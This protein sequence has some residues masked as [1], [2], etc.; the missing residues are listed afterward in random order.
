[1][2]NRKLFSRELFRHPG[3]KIAVLAPMLALGGLATAYAGK[4]APCTDM[5]VTTIISDVDSG[6]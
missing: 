5:P 3:F 4:P 1:M 6:R 2:T